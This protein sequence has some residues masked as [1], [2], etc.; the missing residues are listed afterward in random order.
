MRASRPIAILELRDTHEIGGPGKTILE[1]FRAIDGRKFR[2]HLAVFLT[3]RETGDTPFVGAARA[4]GMPTHFVRG[5]NQYDPRLIARLARLVRELDIDIVHAHEVKSDALTYLASLLHKV[6]IVTTLH[7]WIGNSTKQRLLIGL[8][9]RLVRRFDAVIAVSR[10]IRDEAEASGVPVERL[11]VLHNA[12]VLERYQRSGQT[13]ALSRL[14]GRELARPVIVSVGRLSREK[15]HADLVEAIG[16]AARQ[17]HP[18]TAVFI[19]DGSERPR[20]EEQIAALG[21]RDAIHLPGYVERPD[22]LLEGADLAVLPSHTEGLPN[23]AL[24]ALALEV[25]VLATRVGGTPEVVHDGTTGRLV[26]AHAPAELAAGLMDF[27]RDPQAWQAMAREGRR[28]VERQFN[29]RA[30]T[31]ALEALYHRVAGQRQ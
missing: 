31:E 18:M 10:Q 16:I 6:A 3:E 21:L 27:V 4:C 22:K 8:D 24:E 19:G 20:L 7:G 29:F 1:T 17:G 12:I 15:G 9:R 28:L 25:P 11:H 14:L 2:S 13:G 23:A 5:V 26:A 30:R